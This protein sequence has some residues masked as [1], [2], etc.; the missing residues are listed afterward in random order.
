MAA[1]HL[2][3]RYGIQVHEPAME[4]ARRAT[5]DEFTTARA[6]CGVRVPEAATDYVS[7]VLGVSLFVRRWTQ[8]AGPGLR[9]FAGYAAR[10][11]RSAGDGPAGSVVRRYR[12]G[13]EGLAAET[14][15]LAGAQYRVCPF[16][17]A[18]RSAHWSRK[19]PDQYFAQ[20][21]HLAAYRL[22]IARAEVARVV[23][24][25]GWLAEHGF[26]FEEVRAL[27]AGFTVVV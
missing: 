9:N 3:A 8:R 13:I 10:A 23:A 21:R 25:Q 24:V 26:S 19:F 16:L 22:R 15:K 5:I 27:T 18:W 7:V 20:Q 6:K 14:A 12:S 1:L 4:A 17:R 11:L 2:V